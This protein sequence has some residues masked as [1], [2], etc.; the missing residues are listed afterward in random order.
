MLKVGLKRGWQ[1]LVTTERGQWQWQQQR[2]RT[3]AATVTKVWGDMRRWTAA[4]AIL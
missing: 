2:R 3:A 4:I 1:R